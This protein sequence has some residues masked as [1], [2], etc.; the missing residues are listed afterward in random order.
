[1]KE[2][3]HQS[4]IDNISINTLEKLLN[5]ALS[6]WNNEDA[7]ILNTVAPSVYKEYIIDSPRFY[8]SIITFLEQ[9]RYSGFNIAINNIKEILIEL[10]DK[11]QDNAWRID[12]LLE[13]GNID[14]EVKKS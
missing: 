8:N 11:N 13:G 6:G 4:L 14:L 7:Y 9:N 10:R 2:K 3:K 12:L 1:M 5:K